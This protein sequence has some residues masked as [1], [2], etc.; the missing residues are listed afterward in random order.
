[1]SCRNCEESKRHGENAVY[2]VLY[3]IVIRANYPGCKYDT[4]GK[5]DEKTS[6]TDR[7]GEA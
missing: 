2:C 5:K 7:K 6:E 4:G 1:M 3:G